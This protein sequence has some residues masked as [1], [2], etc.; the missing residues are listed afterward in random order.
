M[1]SLTKENLVDSDIDPD[2]RAENWIT[3]QQDQL[4]VTHTQLVPSNSIASQ[5]AF[6][7]IEDEVIY[8]TGPL[9][10]A[11]VFGKSYPLPRQ[12]AFYGDTGISYSFAG[13]TVEAQPWT[14]ILEH[15]RHLVEV[16]AKTT[17]NSVFV[18]RYATGLNYIGEHRDSDRQLD[19]KA[20]IASLTFG[21][22]RDFYFKHTHYRKG[23]SSRPIVNIKLQDGMLMLIHPP[24]NTFWKHALPVRKRCKAPRINLTFRKMV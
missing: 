10:E 21:V 14:P 20:P 22:C 19:P 17:F 3:V 18:N 2:A 8:L 5:T 15:L 13:V 11:V 6:S 12:Q 23:H 24:T 9:S 7:R 4:M 16:A 1:S